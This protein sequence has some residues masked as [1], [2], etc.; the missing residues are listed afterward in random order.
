VAPLSEPRRATYHHGALKEAL[1]EAAAGLIAARGPE[2]FS[3]LDAARA[4][5]VGASAPYKHFP[6]KAA[7][8]RAVGERGAILLGEALSAAWGGGAPGGFGAMGA[9]Y[10]RFARERPGEYAAMFAT[11]GTPGLR[12][13]GQALAMAVSANAPEGGTSEALRGAIW[14][15]SH[16]AAML[17][18]SGM[19]T[20][21]EADG[22]VRDGVRRLMAAPRVG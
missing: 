16:G 10:L 1:L 22:I 2:G 6:D 12:G 3:L 13:A 7:L 5:G 20:G 14:A 8:L 21:T 19:I 17:E 4:C 18:R 11:R 15:L 9:A